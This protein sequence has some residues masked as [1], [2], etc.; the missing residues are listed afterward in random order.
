[1]A[2]KIRR[3]DFSPD[4]WIA[5]TVGLDNAERGL[6]ITACA[7]MYSAAGPIRIAHLRAACRDHGNAFAR[8]YR[9]L[10]DI[11]KLIE[12]GEEITNKRVE[13]ELENARKRSEN[14]QENGR[15]G[16][17]PP[18]QINGIENPLVSAAGKLARASTINHQPSTIR[19]KDA[20]ASSVDLQTPFERWWEVYP[21]KVGKAAAKAKFSGALKKTSLAELIA[22]VKRYIAV[23]PP[24]RAWCNPA[25]WL[26]Q[27]RWLDE[28]AKRGNSNGSGNLFGESA[29]TYAGRGR[30]AGAG[31]IAA[32]RS[33]S[34][35]RKED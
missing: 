14:A 2:A 1:M 33:V 30:P 15:N 29:P 19:K 4:E 21:E 6:Y 32:L 27:E 9:R 31:V 8:Q 3:V 13:N 5:G 18:K 28:P 12:N 22:G 10:V 16:G 34:F 17:R 23:K 25:T 24:D 35:G 26:H 7:L 20:N 11:G